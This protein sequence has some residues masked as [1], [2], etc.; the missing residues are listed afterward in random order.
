MKGNSVTI[1]VVKDFFWSMRTYGIMIDK[2]NENIYKFSTTTQGVY[3]NNDKTGLYTIWD[4]SAPDIMISELW[5]DSVI[6]KVY[7]GVGIDYAIE[8]G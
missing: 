7:D 2:G 3:L 6:E 5:Y 4:V 1:D 8:E